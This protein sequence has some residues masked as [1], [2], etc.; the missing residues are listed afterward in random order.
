MATI[1]EVINGGVR[2][3][4]Q[5][6]PNIR[7][8]PR[9]EIPPHVRAA[10]WYRDKGA[11]EL[12]GTGERVN[13]VWHI[14]HITPWSAGGSDDSTNLRLLCEPHNLERS[15][16]H[17]PTERPRRAVTW[18]CHRCHA[19]DLQPWDYAPS[20]YACCPVPIHAARPD[21]CRVMQAYTRWAKE[22]GTFPNWHR[23]VEL[24]EFK[25][26]AYCAHCDLPGLT[27]KPL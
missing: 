25:H 15:N 23:R 9:A 27:D 19:D 14:D 18:W 1:A 5:R 2:I 13:A 8:G 3:S 21:W 4:E 10:I 7:T 6:H 11:C 16:Y 12:C 20:G 24:G 22:H 17:D 26:P